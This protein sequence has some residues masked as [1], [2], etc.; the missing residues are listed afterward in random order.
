MSFHRFEEQIDYT[1][2]GF[3][4]REQCLRVSLSPNPQPC[5]HAQGAQRRGARLAAGAAFPALSLAPKR[6]SL[7][8]SSL[9]LPASALPRTPIQAGLGLRIFGSHG[10][11]IMEF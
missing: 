3:K 4:K 1:L 10:L 7:L 11:R 5:T 2:L 9:R 8:R 6:S